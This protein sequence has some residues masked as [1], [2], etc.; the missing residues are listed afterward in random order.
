MLT[1]SVSGLA[2]SVET[3][4]EVFAGTLCAVTDAGY[5]PEFE[6]SVGRLREVG[7]VSREKDDSFHATPLGVAAALTALGCDQA[8]FLSRA[9]RERYPGSGFGW[10]A[11][12]LAAPG[13]TLPAGMLSRY[14]FAESAP[15]RLLYQH[16]D[17]LL[18]EAR[19]LTGDDPTAGRL[20]Y[21]LLVRLK[22]ALLLEQWREQTPV[23]ELE[24]RYGVHLG[25]IVH[26]G[27][28]VAHLI[29]GLGRV[30]EALDNS[31]STARE[32]RDL[33]FSVRFGLAAELREV[34][35]WFGGVLTRSDMIRL[36]AAGLRSVPELLEVSDEE[37]S[38]VFSSERKIL[39]IRKKITSLKEEIDMR[40]TAI[41]THTAPQGRP[42]P[43]V[44]PG[45][46]EIDGTYEKERY[47]VLVD[48][49]PVRLTGKSFKYF[50]KLAWSRI[51]RDTGWIYKED[52]EAG[53][54]QA[55]YLYRMK[56]EINDG[57]AAPWAAIENNRLGYYRLN[58][59]REAIKLNMENL[60]SHPDFEVRSMFAGQR[61]RVVN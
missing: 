35:R 8:E 11:L 53:F 5:R 28:A 1:M 42:A 57:L 52:I 33:A 55:R 40:Q 54:N 30:I 10:I 37:L 50:V 12:V 48:G 31:V 19:I 58:V 3:L 29:A 22:A 47:L 44:A 13:G 51:Q 27:E 25:Q 32:L 18:E 36:G 34:Q 61:D 14:E 26:V 45:S 2:D 43:G 15:L 59:D 56:N 6:V 39:K 16:F 24:E 46:I 49:Y 38:G 7:L 4:G 23:Q 41:S 21:R 60:R 17:H 9:V 20:D